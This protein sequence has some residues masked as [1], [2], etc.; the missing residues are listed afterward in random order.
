MPYCKQAHKINE[1]RTLHNYY[2][3]GK[4][5]IKNSYLLIYLQIF[6]VNK[7]ESYNR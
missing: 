3:I 4:Q 7:R 1:T 2:I 5:L 6:N